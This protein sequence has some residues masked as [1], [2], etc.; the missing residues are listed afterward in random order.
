MNAVIVQEGD[1]MHHVS[2]DRA[3]RQL[4]IRV[5]E[6]ITDRLAKQTIVECL[7]TALEVDEETIEEVIEDEKKGTD[8]SQSPFLIAA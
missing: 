5:L 4:V 6:N 3:Q 7:A 8:N 2:L 1:F